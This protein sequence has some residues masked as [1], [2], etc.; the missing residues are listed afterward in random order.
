MVITYS[1]YLILNEKEKPIIMKNIE[2]DM[3]KELILT[4]RDE[5]FIIFLNHIEYHVMYVHRTDSIGS[6][7]IEFYVNLN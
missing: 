7:K 6:K 4:I 2:R 3:Q 5:R 1:D